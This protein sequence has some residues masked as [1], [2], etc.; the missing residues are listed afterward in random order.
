[1]MAQPYCTAKR[2]EVSRPDAPA[3]CAVSTSTA[4][5]TVLASIM[6]TPSRIIIQSSVV[7]LHAAGSTT[8]SQTS[9]PERRGSRTR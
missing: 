5:T 1:M 2:S 4:P 9:A 7:V 8:A 3:P 6:K